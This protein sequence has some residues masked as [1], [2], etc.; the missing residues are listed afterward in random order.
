MVVTLAFSYVHKEIGLYWRSSPTCD[1]LSLY[2]L[3]FKVIIYDPYWRINELLLRKILVAIRYTS[4]LQSIKPL[5]HVNDAVSMW[6]GVVS[7]LWKVLMIQP[8][9]SRSKG[10]FFIPKNGVVAL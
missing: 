1:T 2:C 9:D 7:F 3:L 8:S 10:Y 5:L 4:D 6:T